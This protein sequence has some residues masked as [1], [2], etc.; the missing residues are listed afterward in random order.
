MDSMPH[1]GGNGNRAAQSFAVVK[2]LS[3]CSRCAALLGRGF[4]RGSGGGRRGRKRAFRDAMLA[5]PHRLAVVLRVAVQMVV[6]AQVR[7]VALAAKS[8][9][10]I[11][12]D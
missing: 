1:C 3:T 6:F 5:L 7:L 10:K 8:D 9:I 12:V 11:A 2:S 4:H